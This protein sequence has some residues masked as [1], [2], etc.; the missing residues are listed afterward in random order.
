MALGEQGGQRTCLEVEQAPQTWQAVA[1]R[2]LERQYAIVLATVRVP[3]WRLQAVRHRPLGTV[4]F[5]HFAE[6]GASS[7]SPRGTVALVGK[8]ERGRSRTRPYR[9]RQAVEVEQATV[10]VCQGGKWGTRPS[11]LT[12][13]RWQLT[14]PDVAD[15]VEALCGVCGARKMC[16][17]CYRR[18]ACGS[19]SRIDKT[20][21]SQRLSASRW[22]VVSHFRLC[23]FGG[24]KEPRKS[25]IAADGIPTASW[26]GVV[27][28]R[29]WRRVD[30]AKR[31]CLTMRQPWHPA[32]VVDSSGVK[33]QTVLCCH[34]RG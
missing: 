22:A 20:A 31:C 5:P 17:G 1:L 33:L 18:Q 26:R 6:R 34:R 2:N 3:L 32:Q 8:A 10:G 13:R 23:T 7:T 15:A 24:L 25:L 30:L 4:R 21:D 19:G 11:E 16:Y 9:P 28:K 27:A 14:S 12:Q 29:H